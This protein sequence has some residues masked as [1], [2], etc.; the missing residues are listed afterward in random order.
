MTLAPKYFILVLL[1]SDMSRKES[2]LLKCNQDL[3]GGCKILEL[4]H[5]SCTCPIVHAYGNLNRFIFNI[6]YSGSASKY[7][8]SLIFLADWVIS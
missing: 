2:F 5:I 7:V 6:K 3:K 1:K 4:E 8:I